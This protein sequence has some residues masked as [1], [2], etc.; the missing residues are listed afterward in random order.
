[1][2][3]RLMITLDFS[4]TI[5]STSYLWYG[6]SCIFVGC[7]G[8]ISQVFIP[9]FVLVCSVIWPFDLSFQIGTCSIL[10]CF[11]TFL[12]IFF[13]FSYLFSHFHL[14]CPAFLD[15]SCS[16]YSVDVVD[17]DQFQKSL[18]SSLPIHY[19]FTYTNI[20]WQSR[21]PL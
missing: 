16:H 12:L 21:M 18:E 13:S 8:L 6:V 11:L 3:C 1:M 14:D 20:F 17:S 7:F 9:N 5:L 15:W 10:A 2:F 4:S 19:L